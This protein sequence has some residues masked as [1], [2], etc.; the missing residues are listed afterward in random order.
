[1]ASML[2]DGQA[3]KRIDGDG[4]MTCHFR[5]I[6]LLPKV[7]EV[8]G[9]VWGADRTEAVVEWQKLG[10]F[11]VSVSEHAAQQPVGKG[12]I[13]HLRADAPIHVDYQWG[14]VEPVGS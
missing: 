10:A 11:R 13:R 1:M 14:R 5:S 8:W 12:G 6:P 7:Y 3:P 9:E 4:V 2:I